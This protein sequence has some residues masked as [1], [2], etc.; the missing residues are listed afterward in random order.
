M[1][2]ENTHYSGLAHLISKTHIGLQDSI[3]SDAT[4]SIA[5]LGK[6]MALIGRLLN[7]PDGASELSPGDVGDLGNLL[8]S[9]GESI[10][11]LNALTAREKICQSFVM[12]AGKNK[13]REV[14]Q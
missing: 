1:N 8:A 4:T 3:E 6:G 7:T 13:D 2:A 14:T 5:V 10:T 11:E 9:L 12:N